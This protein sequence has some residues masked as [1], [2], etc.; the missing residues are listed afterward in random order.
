M[1]KEREAN[2]KADRISLHS[3]E[4]I[5]NFQDWLDLRLR[6]AVLHYVDA[7]QQN[8]KVIYVAIIAGLTLALSVL[9]FLIAAAYGLGSLFGN[10]AWGFLSIGTIM[11]ICTWILYRVLAQIIE[12][13]DDKT[14]HLMVSNNGRKQA[15][16]KSTQ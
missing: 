2:S 8:Q 14:D 16:T 9:F 4:L 5:R 1:V 15:E 6:L 11:G 3:K 7:L 12:N 13:K 10:V